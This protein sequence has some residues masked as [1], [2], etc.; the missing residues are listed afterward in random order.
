MGGPFRGVSVLSKWKLQTRGRW[1]WLPLPHSPVPAAARFC[2]NSE[3]QDGR[4]LTEVLLWRHLT[5]VPMRRRQQQ[6]GSF[7][8]HSTRW[9]LTCCASL[10]KVPNRFL[11]FCALVVWS[12]D[13]EVSRTYQV[14]TWKRERFSTSYAVLLRRDRCHVL[15]VDR[16]EEVTLMLPVI[17]LAGHLWRG[18]P[19]CFHAAVGVT[20]GGRGS[21]VS[22]GFID[23]DSRRRHT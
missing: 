16:K 5:N 15:S 23:L 6:C 22:V 20:C 4:C 3:S 2:S 9:F 13:C 1:A 11:L 10:G 14:E 21:A 17:L 8:A 18:C 12:R 7:L 19:V